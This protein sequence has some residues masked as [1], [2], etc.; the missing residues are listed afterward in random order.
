M[1]KKKFYVVWNGRKIGVFTSWDACQE[2]IENFKGARFKSYPDRV[3]AEKAFKEGPPAKDVQVERSQNEPSLLG[4]PE[5]NSLTVDAACSGNPGD[6][7]Y[8][9]V[10]TATGTEVFKSKVYEMGTNNVGEF[11]AIVHALAWM[12]QQ[13]ISMTI[14]SDSE[15]AIKWVRAGKARTKLEPTAKN[16]AIFDL[17]SRAEAWLSKNAITVP[18]RKWETR[19]WGENP[20]DFGRK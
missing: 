6:M 14:Y 9:G 5:P 19:D 2:Q 7:E 16:A 15:N 17:I 1:A 18:I 10:Y 3:M 13:K 12:Q 4:P 11:L 20:A 8:R